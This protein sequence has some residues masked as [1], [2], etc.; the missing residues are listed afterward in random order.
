LRRLPRWRTD[1]PTAGSEIGL[2]TKA[3]RC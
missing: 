2:D 1:R 3:W